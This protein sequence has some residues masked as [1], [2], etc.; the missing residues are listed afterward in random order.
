MNDRNKLKKQVYLDEMEKV[1][2]LVSK[3]STMCSII[4]KKCDDVYGHGER[5]HHRSGYVLKSL[6]KGWDINCDLTDTIKILKRS[7][8][9]LYLLY[10]TY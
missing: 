3:I 9:H 8:M 5:L 1:T 7:L 10:L 6:K 4:G 2:L